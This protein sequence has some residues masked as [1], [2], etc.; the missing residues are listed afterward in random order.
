MLATVRSCEDASGSCGT[1]IR[2]PDPFLKITLNA[3]FTVDQRGTAEEIEINTSRW[4][5]LVQVGD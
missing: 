4:F 5:I 2:C 1:I 3:L